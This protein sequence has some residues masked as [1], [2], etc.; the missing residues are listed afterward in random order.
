MNKMTHT[1]NSQ[2]TSDAGSQPLLFP[3]L[4]PL[5]PARTASTAPVEVLTFLLRCVRSGRRSGWVVSIPAVPGLEVAARRIEDARGLLREGLTP[6]IGADRA[7]VAELVRPRC[8]CR[9]AWAGASEAISAAQEVH[10]DLEACLPVRRGVRRRAG[11]RRGR[12]RS[13]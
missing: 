6:H 3:D 2:A 9:K 7:A 4:G 12:G 8:A 10:H 11:A 1:G 5:G 13:G